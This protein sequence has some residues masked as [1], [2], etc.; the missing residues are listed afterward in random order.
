MSP[1]GIAGPQN[2]SSP[3]LGKMSIG[4]TPNR[5]KFCG[6]PTRSVRDIRNQKFVL[7]ESEPKFTK[8][9]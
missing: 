2:Q 8:I 9:A 7:P 1:H 3:Y 4:Q 6:D 5:A